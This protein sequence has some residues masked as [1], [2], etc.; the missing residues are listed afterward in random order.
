MREVEKAKTQFKEFYE[1]KAR[2]EREEYEIKMQTLLL[3]K[4]QMNN[5]IRNLETTTNLERTNQSI[6]MN[7]EVVSLNTQ[8]NQ[9]SLENDRLRNLVKELER[10]LE[11]S[12]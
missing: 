5:T 6:A 1:Q 2:E 7:N 8:L 9:K 10:K 3:E 11:D 12:E 4:E